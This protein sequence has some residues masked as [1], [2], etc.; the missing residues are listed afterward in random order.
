MNEDYVNSVCRN[1][2][3]SLRNFKRCDEVL[4]FPLEGEAQDSM[5][6]PFV[7]RLKWAYL[8]LRERVVSRDC[9]VKRGACLASPAAMSGVWRKFGRLPCLGRIPAV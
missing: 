6:I 3:T 1:V 7:F 2:E 5:V 4:A 8:R 9:V